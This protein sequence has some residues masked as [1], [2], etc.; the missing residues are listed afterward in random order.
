MEPDLIES[1]RLDW[2]ALSVRSED[3]HG[4]GPGT[5]PR[6]SRAGRKIAKRADFFSGIAALRLPEE[7]DSLPHGYAG[8]A[9]ISPTS[10]I[11]RA[12]RGWAEPGAD[13]NRRLPRDHFA[14][15]GSAASYRPFATH[16]SDC[17]H[18]G[19]REQ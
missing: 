18:G 15:E 14:P 6:R 19:A 17:P 13:R 4:A 5:R 16:R 12:L 7:F 11:D 2:G 9:R 1:N 3:T 8:A 10:R